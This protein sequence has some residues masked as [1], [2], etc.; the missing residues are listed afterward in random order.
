MHSVITLCVCVCVYTVEGKQQYGSIVHCTV[1]LSIC[2]GCSDSDAD[3]TPSTQ[4]GVWSFSAPVTL[5]HCETVKCT[6]CISLCV[7]VYKNSVH[8]IALVSRYCCCCCCCCAHTHGTARSLIMYYKEQS[9]RHLIAAASGVSGMKC[10]I[11]IDQLSF[12]TH[13]GRWE[14]ML[15]RFWHHT[16]I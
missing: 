3:Q 15:S 12:K 7:C 9:T 11:V 10:F 2:L 8:F 16:L 5:P 13:G 1:V 14:L 4:G 6:Q